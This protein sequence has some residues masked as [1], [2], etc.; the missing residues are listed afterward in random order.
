VQS[1]RAA[2]RFVCGEAQDAA[3]TATAKTAGLPSC[4]IL[5]AI[6]LP[7]DNQLCITETV[8]DADRLHTSA[9]GD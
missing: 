4:R 6:S 2:V 7:S 5:T 3:S 1:F 9:G 8:P